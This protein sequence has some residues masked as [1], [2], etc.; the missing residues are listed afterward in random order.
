MK[1]KI[2]HLFR[3]LFDYDSQAKCSIANKKCF[4]GQADSF[5]ILSKI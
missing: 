5:L 3:G 4:A 1:M 2:L